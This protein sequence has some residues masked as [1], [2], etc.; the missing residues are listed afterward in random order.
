MAL[1]GKLSINSS[2]SE[3]TLLVDPKQS[4]TLAKTHVAL[5]VGHEL[6]HF[7]FGNLT[8]MVRLEVI[9]AHHKLSYSRSGGRT[10]G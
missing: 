7:W 6:A 10:C 2:L 1:L 5:V 8:T 3:I 9:R 4:S